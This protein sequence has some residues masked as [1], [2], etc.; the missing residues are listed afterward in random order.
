[1]ELIYFCFCRLNMFLK[2][3]STFVCVSKLY[4][5]LVQFSTSCT[6]WSSGTFSLFSLGTSYILNLLPSAICFSLSSSFCL[7]VFQLG[8]FLLLLNSL[9]LSSA[10][11][12]P[13]Y[14]ST[15]FLC[16]LYFITSIISTFE[17]FKFFVKNFRLVFYSLKYKY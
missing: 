6:Y 17:N 3:L 13:L 1:M 2:T 8:Y 9:I 4:R 7:S 5:N 11:S 16:W 10:V 15:V 14:S 12:N